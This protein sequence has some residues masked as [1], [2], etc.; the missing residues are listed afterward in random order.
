MGRPNPSRDVSC[1]YG[2]RRI[3]IFPV[4]L[5]TSRIGNLTRL[6]HTLLYVMTIYT[7][8]CIPVTLVEECL[9]SP[10]FSLGLQY[11]TIQYSTIQYLVQ[12]NTIQYKT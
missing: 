8:Y 5:T 1:A 6:I 3:F 7:E 12:Y 11:K 2:D 9:P 4:H 10:H